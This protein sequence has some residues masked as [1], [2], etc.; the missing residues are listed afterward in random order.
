MPG[1]AGKRKRV[2][3]MAEEA[4]SCAVNKKEKACGAGQG[5][6]LG[7]PAAVWV[8]A[9]TGSLREIGDQSRA[10]SDQASDAGSRA[11]SYRTKEIPSADY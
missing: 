1:D 4:G 6:L 8:E 9:D 10:V 7:E 3:R 2:L 11:Q 5:L